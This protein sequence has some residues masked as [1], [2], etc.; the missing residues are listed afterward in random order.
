MINPMTNKEKK[1]FSDKFKPK[2]KSISDKYSW[3]FYQRM[4]RSGRERVYLSPWS[5]LDGYQKPD[6]KELIAGSNKQA[7]RIVIGRLCRQSGWFSGSRLR[8]ICTPG[9]S[10]HNNWAYCDDHGRIADYI[11]I[12]D[13]FWKEYERLGRCLFYNT[14]HEWIAINK[15]SRKCA[16]CGKIQ[17][18]E[19]ITKKEIKRIAVWI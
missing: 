18:R 8:S 3:R 16:Y 13:W 10:V 1:I 9:T 19:V 15:N 5:S 11:E 17:Y 2:E 12:T 6:L 4:K 7:S 14:V